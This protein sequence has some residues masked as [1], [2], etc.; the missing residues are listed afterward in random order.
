MKKAVEDEEVEEE[1][2]GSGAEDEPDEDE[3]LDVDEHD[4]NEELDE[5]EP[6]EDEELDEDG[7]GEKPSEMLDFDF[8]ALPPH[9]E[10]RDGIVDL[11]TQ[12]FILLYISSK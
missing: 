9:E 8:E 5:D 11:L 1:L 6:G 2:V 4:D 3:E 7:E 10:D 12:V